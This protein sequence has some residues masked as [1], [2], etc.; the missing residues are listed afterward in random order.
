MRTL[1]RPTESGEG[2]IEQPAGLLGLMLGDWV[3]EIP[4]GQETFALCLERGE[5][6]GKKRRGDDGWRAGSLSR[7]ICLDR[8]TEA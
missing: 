5:L 1:S 3:V 2:E 6:G 8:G 4:Q 7:G